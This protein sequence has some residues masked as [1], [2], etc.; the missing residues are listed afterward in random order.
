MAV[1]EVTS[2]KAF[3]ELETMKSLIRSGLALE[4]EALDITRMITLDM[5]TY[6]TPKLNRFLAVAAFLTLTITG[7]PGRV[8]RLRPGNTA[9]GQFR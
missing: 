6:I 2:W 5:A 3:T 7:R 4:R 1:P 8:L 9:S